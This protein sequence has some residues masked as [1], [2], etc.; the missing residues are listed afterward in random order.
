MKLK[1]IIKLCESL[2][3]AELR[4]LDEELVRMRVNQLEQL[5]E[6]IKGDA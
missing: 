3:Y 5:R 2:S 4:V 6:Q 1:D